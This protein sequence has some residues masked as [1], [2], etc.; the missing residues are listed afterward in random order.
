LTN[1]PDIPPAQPGRE[2]IAELEA[3][4]NEVLGPPR[5]SLVLKGLLERYA[6]LRVYI[7]STTDLWRAWRNSRIRA[8][9]TGDNHE[10]LAIEWGLTVRQIRTILSEEER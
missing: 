5:G 3:L 7:P 4:L 1:D 6:G 10:P 9:F 8:E 2:F